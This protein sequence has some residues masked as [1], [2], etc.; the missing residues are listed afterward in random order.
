[1]K[2]CG[3]SSFSSKI[4]IS[5]DPFGNT[6]HL[7]NI[8]ETKTKLLRSMYRSLNDHRTTPPFFSL[9]QPL[10]ESILVRKRSCHI[11]LRGHLL[12]QVYIT[13]ILHF[14]LV[15]TFFEDES[16]TNKGQFTISFIHFWYDTRRRIVRFL[17]IKN[18]VYT[19]MTDMRSAFWTKIDSFNQRFY[20]FNFFAGIVNSE[21][22]LWKDQ[23]RFLNEKLRHFGMTY[24][25]NRKEHGDPYYG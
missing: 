5:T 16:T 20:C 21:G 12:T 17:W 1:M 15:K 7:T 18:F 8:Y 22:R 2:L 14:S 19:H 24:L 25:G 9:T 10:R 4:Q 23:R 3:R 13:T 6:A 11:Q